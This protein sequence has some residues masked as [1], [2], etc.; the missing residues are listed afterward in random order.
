MYKQPPCSYVDIPDISL[1]SVKFMD[2]ILALLLSSWL[3]HGISKD[4]NIAV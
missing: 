2:C 1:Y 4:G 3:L